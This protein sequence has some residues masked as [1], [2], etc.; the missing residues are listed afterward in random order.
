MLPAGSSR[1]GLCWQPGFYLRLE[2][3]SFMGLSETSEGFCQVNCGHEHHDCGSS[4]PQG[5]GC[6]TDGLLAR[7]IGVLVKRLQQELRTGPTTMDPAGAAT[8][9]RDRSDTRQLLYFAGRS[10]AIAITAEG[11]QQA[12]LKNGSCFWKTLEDVMVR[13]LSKQ[14]NNLTVEF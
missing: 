9:L 13:M 5:F 2:A 12:R 4:F 14:L 1:L 10:E 6:S 8:L 7:Q 3:Y 11:G